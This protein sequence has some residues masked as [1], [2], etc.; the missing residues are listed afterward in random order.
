MTPYAEEMIMSSTESIDFTYVQGHQETVLFAIGAILAALYG[1]GSFIPFSVFIG[2]EATISLALLITPLFGILLGPWRGGFFGLVG[3]TIAFMVGGAEGL[4]QL[5]PFLFLAPA[6]SG[7]L[8]GLCGHPR[9]GSLRV[10]GGFITGAYLTVVIVLYEIVDFEGWWFM[11]Y[12]F[13]A[14]IAALALQ[15]SDSSLDFNELRENGILRLVLLAI[16]GTI[17][18]FSLMTMGAVYIFQIPALT[19]GFVVFPLMLFERSTA[20]VISV[21]LAIAIVRAFPTIWDSSFT[22]ETQL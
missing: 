2:G 13:V 5:I 17:T 11:S 15:V 19:F 1:L 20:I 9:Q 8:T 12:Y 21:I 10:P 3:G 16:I 7:L 6:I 4:Y 18:D 22:P 14:V